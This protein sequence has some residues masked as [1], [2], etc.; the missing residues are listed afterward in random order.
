MRRSV[1]HPEALSIQDTARLLS[2]SE[3][4]IRNWIQRGTLKAVRLGP[5]L[6]RIPRTELQ[7]IRAAR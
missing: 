5:K 3:H 2:V 1:V 6:W 4:T 7:R